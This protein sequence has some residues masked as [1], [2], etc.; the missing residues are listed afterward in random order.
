MPIV[1]FLGL[2]A[3]LASFCVSALGPAF[4][5]GADPSRFISSIYANGHEEA[6]WLQWLSAAKRGAWFSRDLTALWSRCDASARKANDKVGPLDA[7]VAT[8]SQM[9]WEA[10][11]GFTV[12]VVSQADGL[13]VVNA[14][15]EPGPNTGPRKA[16]DNVVRYDL[17][18]EGGDWK[19]DD[20][21]STIDGKPWSLRDLLKDYLKTN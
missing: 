18:Q 3:I 21:H 11:K 16:S 19:I 10:F 13:A 17:I 5:G 15:L 4:A 8:N 7:D 14:K 1:R 2:V 6:V 20:V 12:S 9:G